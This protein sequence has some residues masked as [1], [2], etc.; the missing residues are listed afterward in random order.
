MPQIKTETEI[1]EAMQTI[2]LNIEG[3]I[4]TVEELA[5]LHKQIFDAMHG[6]LYGL[7]GQRHRLKGDIN[8]ALN[9]EQDAQE[10]YKG[11]PENWKW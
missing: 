8:R 9:A 3:Q 1:A 4:R 7:A 6:F 2:G 5:T 10:Y 11:M